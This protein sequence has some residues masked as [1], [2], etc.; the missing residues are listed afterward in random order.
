MYV[1]EHT[2]HTPVVLSVFSS[3]L[4]TF[5]NVDCFSLQSAGTLH[6]K[7]RPLDYKMACDITKL[8]RPDHNLAPATR[9]E[10]G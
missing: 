6:Y 8:T 1:K 7:V 9:A 4:R 10:N 3:S 2:N 5:V